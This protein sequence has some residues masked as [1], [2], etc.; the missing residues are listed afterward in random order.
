MACHAQPGAPHEAV[1]RPRICCFMRFSSGLRRRRRRWRDRYAANFQSGGRRTI[2][3]SERKT[4]FIAVAF[5]VAESIALAIAY[6]LT[7][8]DA[9]Y[10]Y[11]FADSDADRAAVQ[12]VG[13]G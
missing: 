13:G 9:L 7:D 10:A 1:C 8:S 3:I 2:A 11:A 6:A 4:V 12:R 5:A